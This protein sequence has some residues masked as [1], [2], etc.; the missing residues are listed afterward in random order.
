MLS[1][2]IEHKKDIDYDWYGLGHFADF[3][4]ALH[5]LLDASLCVANEN[6]NYR[7][8]YFF[9]MSSEEQNAYRRKSCIV[10]FLFRGHR[11]RDAT[12]KIVEAEKLCENGKFW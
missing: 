5:D 10:F 12:A 3:F 6:Q 9:E 2:L 4:V 8:W 11:I 7:C 1:K